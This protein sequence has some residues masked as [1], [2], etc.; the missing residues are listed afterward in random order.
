MNPLTLVFIENHFF[1]LSKR[2]FLLLAIFPFFF[3][4]M[5]QFKS[6][7]F[8]IL[9]PSKCLCWNCWPHGKKATQIS[10]PTDTISQ[11]RFIQ[12]KRQRRF[13]DQQNATLNIASVFIPISSRSLSLPNRQKKTRFVKTYR[14]INWIR[15]DAVWTVK[16]RAKK[17]TRT[18]HHHWV[19]NKIFQAN[20]RFPLMNDVKVRNRKVKFNFA[21]KIIFPPQP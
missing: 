8:Y 18:S 21:L 17:S 13:P 10:N 19:D 9:Q 11:I 12:F 7:P 1:C 16:N 20:R 2:Q 4:Q 3:F 6:L 15:I 5:R 14:P